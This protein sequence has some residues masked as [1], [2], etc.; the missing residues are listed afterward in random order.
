MLITD[1]QWLS[2]GI[3]LEGPDENELLLA[4]TCCLADADSTTAESQSLQAAKERKKQRIAYENLRLSRLSVTNQNREGLE[5]NLRLNSE[6]G[7][8]DYD[9]VLPTHIG[10]FSASDGIALSETPENGEVLPRSS[11]DRHPSNVRV[12]SCSSSTLDYRR[13]REDRGSKQESVSEST[14][15]AALDAG[16]DLQR[17]CSV[18]SKA[19]SEIIDQLFDEIVDMNKVDQTLVT[20]ASD[21]E[22]IGLRNI[23]PLED[24]FRQEEAAVNLESNQAE[25]DIAGGSSVKNAN[26]QLYGNCRDVLNA[27]S[28]EMNAEREDLNKKV[29]TTAEAPPPISKVSVLRCDS[30]FQSPSQPQTDDASPSGHPL[31]RLGGKSE[32]KQA[33]TRNDHDKPQKP[34]GLEKPKPVITDK[35]KPGQL[36]RIQPPQRPP[37]TVGMNQRD[38][39]TV[40]NGAQEELSRQPN[41]WQQPQKPEKPLHPLIQ[42]PPLSRTPFASKR[43][44]DSSPSCISQIQSISNRKTDDRVWVAPSAVPCSTK[45]SLPSTPVIPV[46]QRSSLIREVVIKSSADVPS[47]LESLSV[48]GVSQCLE[49]LH[50]DKHTSDFNRNAV[51]GRKLTDLNEKA[52][53]NQFHFTPLDASKLVRFVRGWRP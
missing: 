22:A 3:L 36:N 25:D 45:P 40:A 39:P 1:L 23:Q 6:D 47:E 13:P 32:N 20:T 14:Q 9:D 8:N 34:V 11:L 16:N 19:N 41:R 15:G 43:L 4:S 52:L 46:A 37:S 31:Q 18:V 53:E 7:T 27:N 12:V 2:L 29:S 50:L 28:I 17:N 30:K 24:N 33:D 38:K 49:L 26:E 48:A 10:Q 44:P 35:P 51:D 5:N 42:P 21:S